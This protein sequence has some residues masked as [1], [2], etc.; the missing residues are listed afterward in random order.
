MPGPNPINL[1]LGIA[2]ELSKARKHRGLTQDVLGHKAHVS[3]Q[4]VSMIER[5]EV[6]DPHVSALAALARALGVSVDSLCGSVSHD[7]D[8]C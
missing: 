8:I 3:P 5:G 7:V 1:C 4:L 6:K 2:D